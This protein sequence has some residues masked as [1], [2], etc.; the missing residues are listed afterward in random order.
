MQIEDARYLM[1]KEMCKWGLIPGWRAE[2]S[3][4]MTS[5]LGKCNYTRKKLV[6]SAKF[7]T[8][9]NEAAVLDTIRH[10]IAHALAGSAA[11]HGPKWK[12]KCVLVGCRPQQYCSRELINITY[13]WQL[14]Y[15]LEG[16]VVKRFESFTNRRSDL[17]GRRIRCQPETL[18][19]LQWV[20]V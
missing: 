3:N 12:E 17:T 2:I 19:K 16:V 11:E 8:E 4:R 20:E 10:E 13:K 5:V 6:L 7:I 15:L 18:N 14:A 1:Q 9:N